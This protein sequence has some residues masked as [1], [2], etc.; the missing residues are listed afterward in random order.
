MNRRK[1]LDWLWSE[2]GSIG[3][4]DNPKSLCIRTVNTGYTHGISSILIADDQANEAPYEVH[5][6]DAIDKAQTVIHVGLFRRAKSGVQERQYGYQKKVI[7]GI[8]T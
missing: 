7:A 2:N 6:W 3:S 4:G 5:E 8:C 1:K